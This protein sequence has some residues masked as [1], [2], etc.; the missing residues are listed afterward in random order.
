MT[1]SKK[2]IIL[3]TGSSGCLGQFIVK[4]LQE[5]DDKVAEIRLYDRRPFFNRLNIPEH[6]KMTEYLADLRHPKLLLEATENVDCVIHAASLID[7]SLLPDEKAMESINVEG[8]QRV[9][10]ACIKNNVPRLVF[11]ST[12]D[13]ICG[14]EHIFYGTESTTPIPTSCMIG[15]YGETKCKAEDLIIKAS[16]MLCSNGETTLRTVSLRPTPFFGESDRHFFIPFLK[17]ANMTG[18]FYHRIRSLD[19]R[20]QISYVGNVAW[21]FCNAKDKLAVDETISGEA[22][23]I[24]DDT[25]IIDI[26][27]H[28][29]PYLE[30]RGFGVSTYT[31]PYWIVWLLLSIICFFIRLIN[32]VITFEANVPS[33]NSL[34]YM[35]ST[36][37]FNRS[38]ATLRLDY[39]PL[40]PPEEALKRSL[41]YYTNFPLTG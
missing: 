7:L 17:Y 36:F 37:F 8:T 30:A 31:I 1:P 26:H 13:M 32:V 21:A 10:D 39:E 28:L 12:T 15:K 20:L 11:A 41:P 3:V 38:K 35:C 6:K 5:R 25:P 19:E 34:N 18:G 27:E 4:L 40:Y 16:G 23:F 22:F 14:T 33:I 2:E 24:T 29:Q 9:I